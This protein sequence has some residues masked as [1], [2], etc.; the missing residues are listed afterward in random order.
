MYNLYFKKIS[1]LRK[2][3]YNKHLLAGNAFKNAWR[4]LTNRTF[5]A[6]VI[7]EIRT[8]GYLGSHIYFKNHLFIIQS[9]I[10][11]SSFAKA[12]T[13]GSKKRKEERDVSNCYYNKG[14][15]I[16]GIVAVLFHS[17]RTICVNIWVPCNYGPFSIHVSASNNHP[18]SA[19]YWSQGIKY[20]DELKHH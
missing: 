10:C 17:N 12:S 20:L 19:E 18:A 13:D 14:K 5:H 3:F 1:F 2:I 7:N 9:L 8:N 6:Y 4:A 16:C 11:V 15:H